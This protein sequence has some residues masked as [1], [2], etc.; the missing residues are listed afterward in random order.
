MSQRQR[1]GRKRKGFSLIEVLFAVFMSLMC[2]TILAATMPIATASRE[3]AD[4]NNKATSVAQKQLEAIR[5]LGYGNITPNQLLAYKLIDSV[6]PVSDST[7]SFKNVDK[8]AK[9]SV[10]NVL[11]GGDGNVMIEQIDT[12]L[13]RVTVIVTYEDRSGKQEV[14][15]ATLVANL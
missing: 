12:D 8:E 1:F 9:D 6:T 7:Y 5:G 10:A 14:R 2:A 11:K 3:R 15:L 13:R 4:A